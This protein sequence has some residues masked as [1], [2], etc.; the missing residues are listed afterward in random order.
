MPDKYWTPLR[1]EVHA[2]GVRLEREE[3]EAVKRCKTAHEVEQCRTAYG[4][5]FRDEMDIISQRY[6]IKPMLR[7]AI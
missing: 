3:R 1:T 5:L 4:K 7:K 2:L 6:G